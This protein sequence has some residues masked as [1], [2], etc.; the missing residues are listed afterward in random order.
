MSHT[1]DGTL[2]GPGIS[3]EVTAKGPSK[4]S[5]W[6]WPALPTG[7]PSFR[8]EVEFRIPGTHGASFQ[9]PS[10]L[11]QVI[12]CEIRNLPT[13]TY[14]NTSANG[15]PS[16][17]VSKGDQSCR[18][19]S[20]CKKPTKSCTTSCST[21]APQHPLD[22]PGSPATATVANSVVDSPSPTNVVTLA[23]SPVLSAAAD[24]EGSPSISLPSSQR[25]R[26]REEV[27]YS[28]GD[29]DEGS[30]PCKKSRVLETQDDARRQ[31]A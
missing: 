16:T 10:L 12:R 13:T 9:L 23:A 19:R 3:V 11:D 28:S 29:E 14:K 27:D 2:D 15:V 26:G 30:S 7:K 31:G 21:F 5:V 24:L 8:G 17:S 18:S 20:V 1:I 4:V 25:K 6:S 22:V